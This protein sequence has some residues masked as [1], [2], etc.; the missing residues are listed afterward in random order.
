VTHLLVPPTTMQVAG[1]VAV[2]VSRA[3]LTPGERAEMFALIQ[4][5]FEGVRDDVF[6]RDLDEK[7]WVR[8]GA[9]GLALRPDE[10]A[11]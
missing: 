1:D 4:S 11:G 7:D 10:R 2:P 8:L 3:D 9:D 6:N 5:H